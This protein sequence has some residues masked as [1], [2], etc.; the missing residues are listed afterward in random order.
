[1]MNIEIKLRG[2]FKLVKQVVDEDGNVGPMVDATDWFDNL[3]TNN[4]LD[5]LGQQT[6]ASKL[7]NLRVGSGSTP[8]TVTD[9]TLVST[10]ANQAATGAGPGD[11]TWD[12]TSVS[13]YAIIKKA[14]AYTFAKGAA[15]GNLTEIGIA[16]S[17]TANLF[18]RCLIKD[19]SGNPITVTVLANEILTVYYQ[20]WVY[21]PITD[22]TQ[23]FTGTDSIARTITTRAYDVGTGGASQEI[24]CGMYCSN[25]G[26]S[27]FGGYA[28]G[29]VGLVPYTQQSVPKT[30]SAGGA[31]A[32]Y[33]NGTYYCDFSY[34]FDINTGNNTPYGLTMMYFD[35][36]Y[37]HWQ[38]Q[39]SPGIV[40]DNTKSM[41]MVW[42]LSW[43]RYAP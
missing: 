13:G 1:M 12:T 33:T 38:A 10:V 7:T 27:N 35:T 9:T 42:R 43:S 36:P 20:L 6:T 11:G 14:V 2:R 21:Q 34:S 29:N 19:D 30:A 15:A 18:S 37:G 16:E 8:P 4:G 28:V 31:R 25:I 26:W 22:G 23:S 3:I 40:K 17:N 24:G 41:T 5:W 32:A 39:I